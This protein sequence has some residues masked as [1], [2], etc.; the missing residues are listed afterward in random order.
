MSGGENLKSSCGGGGGRQTTKGW[1]HFLLGKLTPET[2]SKDF[3]L[4]I[5]GGIGW[6]K[7]LKNGGQRKVLYFIQ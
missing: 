2:P 3:H 4:A 7:W 5:G 1:D 6:M